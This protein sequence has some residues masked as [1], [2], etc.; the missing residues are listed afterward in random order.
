M[1][2]MKQ[3]LS[4]AAVLP[5]ALSAPSYVAANAETRSLFFD[6]FSEYESGDPPGGVWNNEI[7]QFREAFTQERDDGTPVITMTD[8]DPFNVARVV[9]QF[10]PP[11]EDKVVFEF[12]WN[13][14]TDRGY[15]NH[16]GDGM[17]FVPAVYLSADSEG[18]SL[19]TWAATVRF[20]SWDRMSWRYRISEDEDGGENQTESDDFLFDEPLQIRVHYTRSTGAVLIQVS[21]D[22]FETVEW[23]GEGDGMPGLDIN[24]VAIQSTNRAG[25]DRLYA[26]PIWDINYVSVWGEGMPAIGSYA[27]WVTAFLQEEHP[28]QTGRMDDPGGFGVSNFARYAFAL[29]PL[30]PAEASLEAIRLSEE[31]EPLGL[32]F[33]RYE[34]ID[35]VAYAVESASDPAGPWEVLPIDEFPVETESLGDGREE[36]VVGV[37]SEE[38]RAFYRMVAGVPVPEGTIFYEDFEGY[39]EGE[40][41]G[42]PWVSDV[43]EGTEAWVQGPAG[44][45]YLTMTDESEEDTADMIRTFDTE[46]AESVSVTFEW[47]RKTGRNYQDEQGDAPQ[48]APALVLYRDVT[49]PPDVFTDNVMVQYGFRSWDRANLW[50]RDDADELPRTEIGSD[51]FLLDEP[52]KIR[53][54]YHRAGELM[55]E[56]SKDDFETVEWSLTQDSVPDANVNAVGIRSANRGHETSIYVSPIWET[57]SV[58][59]TSSD[60]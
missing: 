11:L 5:L 19:G 58:L 26:D 1:S 13:R 33:R 59:V 20:R 35:D 25:D 48:N 46:E 23:E 37:G 39:S 56:V 18:T 31:E 4:M 9:A 42:E 6:D 52:L 57:R 41:P 29:E 44:S 7:D 8:T 17:G 36:V 50:L 21:K 43:P 51:D 16:E 54:T 40:T 28:E 22:Q 10:D 27:N 45:R 49:D 53:M 24:A 34:G 60:E 32:R 3:L 14:L 30:R 15:E 12:E 47:N 2:T 55:V 38:E